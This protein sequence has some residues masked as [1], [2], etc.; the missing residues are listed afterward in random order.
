MGW[1]EEQWLLATGNIQEYSGAGLQAR[2][3]PWRSTSQMEPE[4]GFGTRPVVLS[5]AIST[6]LHPPECFQ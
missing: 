5:A 3:S 6:S 2:A 4:S 1:I